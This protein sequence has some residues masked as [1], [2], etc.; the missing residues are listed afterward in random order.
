MF[1]SLFQGENPQSR[2][3]RREEKTTVFTSARVWLKR[4]DSSW[5]RSLTWSQGAAKRWKRSG[6]SWKK[7]ASIQPN[8]PLQSAQISWSSPASFPSL[9]FLNNLRRENV[10]DLSDVSLHPL[11]PPHPP[12][13]C[14]GPPDPIELPGVTGQRS[15][16]IG[17]RQTGLHQGESTPPYESVLTEDKNNAPSRQRPWT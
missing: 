16:D 17:G 14:S 8:N 3:E 12:P 5:Q 15:K 7:S 1:L 6:K 9:V 10:P 11:P 2:K 4:S 13:G